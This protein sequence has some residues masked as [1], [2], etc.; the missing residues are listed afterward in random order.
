MGPYGDWLRFP[1]HRKEEDDEDHDG[2]MGYDPVHIRNEID[3]CRVVTDRTVEILQRVL[4]SM[5]ELLRIGSIEPGAMLLD[6][7]DVFERGGRDQTAK[8]GFPIKSQFPKGYVGA[9]KWCG[10]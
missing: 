9:D 8:Y 5:T 1:Y 4:S 10:R 2:N 6:V 7:N 3:G